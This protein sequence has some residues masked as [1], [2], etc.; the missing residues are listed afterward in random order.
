[1]RSS[2]QGPRWPGEEPEIHSKGCGKPQDGFKVGGRWPGFLES[3][4]RLLM[5][6]Q[7]GRRTSIGEGAHR[8]MLPSHRR[9]KT[10]LGPSV[11]L[12]QG[13]PVEILARARFSRHSTTDV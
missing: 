10:H 12:R 2:Y 1:M 9:E 7:V 6:S 3:C 8:R 4:P 13:G 11:V 5:W